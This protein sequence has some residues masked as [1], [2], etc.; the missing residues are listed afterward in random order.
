METTEPL[1]KLN[2]QYRFPVLPS[3]ELD[4]EKTIEHWL[5]FTEDYLEYRCEYDAMWLQE[6]NEDLGGKRDVQR[7]HD[8]YCV[9]KREFLTGVDLCLFF[10]ENY[11][12]LKIFSTGD[13]LVVAIRTREKAVLMK[14]LLKEYIF[15]K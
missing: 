6:E 8:I 4:V 12:K 1:L 13:T 15:N 7:H 14:N 10:D 9:L 11:Y 3:K 2:H 5:L